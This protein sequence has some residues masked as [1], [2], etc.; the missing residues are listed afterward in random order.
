MK[1]NLVVYMLGDKEVCVF[2]KGFGW[3]CL[4]YMGFMSVSLLGE[5][6]GLVL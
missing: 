4:D 2:V 1:K 6:Q 3:R 5:F